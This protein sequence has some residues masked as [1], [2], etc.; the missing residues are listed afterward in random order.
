MNQKP[1]NRICKI[2]SF[3]RSGQEDE[4]NG[5]LEIYQ[6]FYIK[7]SVQKDMLMP[8]YQDEKHLVKGK[9]SKYHLFLGVISLG[10]N[11]VPSPKIFI[12]L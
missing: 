1:K 7:Y 10:R 11:E 12:M 3:F 8:Y 2:S 6:R 4:G 9:S 5:D